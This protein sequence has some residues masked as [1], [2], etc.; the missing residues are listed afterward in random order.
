MK[1]P[2]WYKLVDKKPVECDMI[3]A[4]KL[5]EDV[6]SRVVATDEFGDIVVSTVFLGLDHNFGD[7]PPI[8]FETMIF[9]GNFSEYQQRYSTW[10]EAE[11]GHRSITGLVGLSLS[12]EP[13]IKVKKAKKKVKKKIKKDINFGSVGRSLDI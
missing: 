1:M 2:S 9:G 3:E 6:A 8:L 5:I 7:G 13:E 10:E 12:S 11:A 4:A